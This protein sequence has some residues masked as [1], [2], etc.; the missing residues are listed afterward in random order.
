MTDG[1]LVPKRIVLT[2]GPSGGKTT[3]KN[4]LQE[5]LGD[6]GRSIVFTPTFIPEVATLLIGCGLNPSKLTPEQY[7][8]FQRLIFKTQRA[9]EEQIFSRAMEI[10]AADKPLVICDR[11]LMDGLAYMTPE[12][13]ADILAENKMTEVDARDRRYDGVFHL[14]TVADG[15]PELYSNANNPARMETAEEAVA[16]DQKTQNAWLGHPHLRVID[17]STDFK[18]KMRRL[19]N[20][21]RRLLGD[22][23][24]VETERWF[25]V[26]GGVQLR[27]IP[28]PFKKINI[29]QVYL[30]GKTRAESR[31]RRRSQEDSNAVY[32]ETQKGPNIS[33][34]SR[35]E[36]EWQISSREYGNKLRFASPDHDIIR[37][38][39]VCFLWKNQYIELDFFLEPRR[40]LGLVKLEIELTEE[41]DKV[42]IPDWLGKVEEVT[43]D[44][45]YGNRELARRP[46]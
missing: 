10:R 16:I 8:D 34:A 19:L 43:G 39:R 46:K 11:G 45:Q 27:K 26:R 12:M 6:F 17:N 22:P 25:I 31:I 13:F 9:F 3:G 28:V 5:N 38:N 7:F 41:N 4:F 30:E 36:N 33:A 23:V 40:L 14:K 2:G 44:P 20:E 37:K 35:P 15:K 29:E 18:Q 32:Y 24:A 42:E 21:V 1:L